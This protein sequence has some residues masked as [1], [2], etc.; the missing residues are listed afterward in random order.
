AM[1]HADSRHWTDRALVFIGTVDVQTQASLG[2]MLTVYHL[3]TGDLERARVVLQLMRAAVASP[4]TSDLLRTTILTT[5]AMGYWFFAENDACIAVVEQTEALMHASD[6][7]L[8][9]HAL[10]NHGLAA[11]IS[12]GNVMEAE[13]FRA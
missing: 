1:G 11:A 5:E 9:K 13:S 4:Q 8:W 7:Y 12:A 3:W 2:F 10:L 6:I